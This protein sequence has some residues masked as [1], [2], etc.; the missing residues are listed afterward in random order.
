MTGEPA[1]ARPRATFSRRRFLASGALA[2]SGAATVAAVDARWFELHRL[3][4]V[5]RP[6]PVAGLPAALAGARLAHLSDL[7]VGPLVDDEYVLRTFE[8]V[9]REAPDLVVYT[10]DFMTNGPGTL[11]KLPR[12]YAR[13]PRGR[14]ATLGVL[15]NH[16]YG[17]GWSHPEIAGRVADLLR[18]QGIDVLRNAV[19]EVAGLQFAGFDD[20]WAGRFDSGPILA[21]L[22]RAR[23]HVTLSHNPDTADLEGMRTLRGWILSGHTHGGQVRLPPFP[24]PVLP[25]ANRRYAAGEVD[26]GG[27]RRLY[28]SR[29]VGHLTPVRFGVRPEV[30]LFTLVPVRAG[31]APNALDPPRPHSTPPA[32]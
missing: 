12:I 15:G 2:L 11:D 26:L 14:L 4:M 30:T 13:A 1:A 16:D 31:H 24:P 19:R 25:V 32:A 29:G 5:R 10:G 3:E 27:G 17:K 20:L 9:R 22:D 23:A 21:A 6:M 28:V 7:H 18:E 8:R